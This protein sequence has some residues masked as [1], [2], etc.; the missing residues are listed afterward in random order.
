ML[1]SVQQTGSAFRLADG[2]TGTRFCALIG[3]KFLK[4]HI[5]GSYGVGFCALIGGK[6]VPVSYIFYFPGKVHDII[7]EKLN[8]A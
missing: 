1:L 2:R 6:F 7:L 4:L 3:G 5:S 8:H